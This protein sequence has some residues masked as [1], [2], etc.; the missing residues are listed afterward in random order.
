MN[1]KE[2]ADKF[3]LNGAAILNVIHY[4]ALQSVSRN[5]NYVRHADVIEGIRKEYRKE[6]RTMK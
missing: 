6:E 4:A 3:E 2:L 5:D 1:L